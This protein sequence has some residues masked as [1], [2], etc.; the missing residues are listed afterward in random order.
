VAA[1]D[2]QTA[3]YEVE[4]DPE[5]KDELGVLMMAFSRM[6]LEVRRKLGELV[7]SEALQ[8]KYLQDAIRRQTEKGLEGAVVEVVSRARARVAAT[9]S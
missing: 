4:F 1:R 6:G 5:R 9:L 2:I 7:H 3:N 8:R